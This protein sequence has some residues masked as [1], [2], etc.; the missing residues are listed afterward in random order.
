MLFFVVV[1]FSLCWLGLVKYEDKNEIGFSMHNFFSVFTS[2]FFLCI[3]LFMFFLSNNSFNFMLSFPFSRPSLILFRCL[4]LSHSAVSL[5]TYFSLSNS[6]IFHFQSLSLS[7]YHSLHP[8][9]SLSHSLY[10][11]SS[12]KDWWLNTQRGFPSLVFTS[13]NC[14][15]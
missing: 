15:K 2:Y 13:A 10:L 12:N 14:D 8:S 9:L 1:L 5:I 7:Q 11:L 3:I 4:S 6:Y